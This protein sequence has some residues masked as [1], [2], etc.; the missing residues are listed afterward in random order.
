[1]KK[2]DLAVIFFV[3]ILTAVLNI[4]NGTAIISHQFFTQ[5]EDIWYL[6]NGMLR[7]GIGFCW[8]FI[9][10]YGYRCRKKIAIFML[11]DHHKIQKIE[12]P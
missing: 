8:L 4:V 12:K 1:M 2:F 11:H 9:G 5:N 3:V 10:L 6:F 7:Y